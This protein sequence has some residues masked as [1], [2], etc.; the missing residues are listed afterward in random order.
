MQHRKTSSEQFISNLIQL[1]NSKI[2][3]R[4]H[5]LFSVEICNQLLNLNVESDYRTMGITEALK[6][7]MEVQKQLHEQLEVCE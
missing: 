7:Q 4:E 3:W 5:F 1:A 2:P 6:M